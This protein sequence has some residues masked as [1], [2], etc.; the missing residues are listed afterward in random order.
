[1]SATLVTLDRADGMYILTATGAEATTLQGI[2][3]GS[4]TIDTDNGVAWVDPASGI[5]RGGNTYKVNKAAAILVGALSADAP[6]HG[7]QTNESNA[8]GASTNTKGV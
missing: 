5:S 2:R 8:Y 6:Q 3:D 1:V 7:P 4:D